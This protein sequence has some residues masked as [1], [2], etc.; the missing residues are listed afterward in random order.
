MHNGTAVLASL[1]TSN[2][3]EDARTLEPRARALE[4]R[5]TREPKTQHHRMKQQQTRNR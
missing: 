4:N 2:T 5:F 3:L 1:V